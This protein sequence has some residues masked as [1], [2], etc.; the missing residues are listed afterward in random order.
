MAK[1]ILGVIGGMGPA[2]SALFMQMVVER[3]EA[4]RDCRHI[5]T[6]MLS[7]PAIPDR[8][9]Y[10]LGESDEN[11]VP[12]IVG[13]GKKL[14]ALGADIIAVPCITANAFYGTLS[15]EIPV[16]VINA[17]EE[18]AKY[19]ADSG[20]KSAGVLATEGAVQSGVFDR[21]FSKAGIRLSIP[22]DAGRRE[23]MRLIYGNVKAGEPPDGKGLERAAHSL[24]EKGAEC[25]VL[26][27]TELSVIRRSA[28]IRGGFLD[29][30]EVL[31]N[32]AV[33]YCGELKSEYGRLIY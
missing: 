2:A 25:V 4:D 14:A 32:T 33:S 31:A 10:I 18:T 12:Y 29:V 23:V 9:R 30:L 15:E 6:Y 19:L 13:A 20:V 17:V 3:T 28:N 21:A 5:E 11:P 26:G 27:C 8:T 22:D 24:L 7:C 1:K 16:P